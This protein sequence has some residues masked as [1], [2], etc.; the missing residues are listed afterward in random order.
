M[1]VGH[2]VQKFRVGSVQLFFQLINDN[3]VGIYGYTF[4]FSLIGAKSRDSANKGRIFD[5]DSVYGDNKNFAGNVH[6][7]KEDTNIALKKAVE[8]IG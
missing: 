4:N 5:N 1:E 2:D 8:A 6:K 3:A 7:F